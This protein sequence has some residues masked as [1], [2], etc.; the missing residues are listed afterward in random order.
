MFLG[1]LSFNAPEWWWVALLAALALIPTAYFAWKQEG[2]LERGHV[3]G[4]ALRAL[5]V[6]LLILCLLDPHWTGER[7][8][9][10]ANIVAIVADN[11]QG[12]NLADPD[13]SESR[14]QVLKSWLAGM[15]SN[16]LDSL[17]EDYQTRSYRFDRDLRR[18]QDFGSL[19]FTGDRS[20]LSTSLSQLRDRFEGLPL[21]GV[22]LFT[23]GIATDASD[24]EPLNLENLPPIYPVSLG[25]A[26]QLPDLS[27]DRIDVRQTAFDDAPVSLK[28]SLSSNGLPTQN[29]SVSISP[30]QIEGDIPGL[31][32]D[33]L[34]RP[35]TIRPR[36]EGS[37]HSLAFDWRPARSGVQFFQVETEPSLGTEQEATDANNRRLFKVEGGQEA[38]RILYVTGRPNWEYKFLNRA[39]YDDLQLQMSGLIR[40]AKREPK[41]EFKGRAGESSNPLFRGFDGEEEETADYDQPV[42]VRVNTRDA[43]ELS[44]GFP[45]TAEELFEYDALIIDDLEAEFFNFNQQ[46]LIRRFVSERGGGLLALGGADALDHGGYDDTPIAATLPIYLDKRFERANSDNLSWKLTREGWVEPWTRVRPIESDERARLNA[47]P[48]F[49][50]LNTIPRIKPGARILAEVENAVGDRYP[51]LIAHNFGAGKVACIAVG[52]LWRWGMRGPNEQEDLARLWRQ[53]ARWLVTD[54][55]LRV[56]IDA[57]ESPS[58]MEL[59]VEARDESYKPLEIGRARITVKR[60]DLDASELESHEGFKEVEMYADPVANAP[61][62]FAASFATLDEGAYLAKVEVVDLDG[63]VIGSDETGWVNEPL[64]NEFS[65]LVPRTDILYTIASETGGQVLDWNDL[66]SVKELFDKSSAAVTEVWAYPIWHNGW[67]FLAALACLLAEW[68]LRRKRGLA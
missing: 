60:V 61:G 21:A 50:V 36:Q 48:S 65:A 12:L 4:F 1:A 45:D 53:I 5:G 11:S 15:E 27:I 37:R 7:P 54:V 8:A 59:I 30:V 43:Q 39:L 16:W 57:Q 6:L 62:R 56:E 64:A 9:K 20:N 66:A 52:D 3:L 17:G 34:P 28:V 51:S 18:V 19:D 32:E 22:L 58:G 47:M 13:K 44:D 63:Q 46:T 14:G 68:G 23:D 2:R 38:F 35:Q 55:P 33:D 67:L 10:G 29:A 42:L 31:S 25:S 24:L 49:S 26:D 41:F 40:V